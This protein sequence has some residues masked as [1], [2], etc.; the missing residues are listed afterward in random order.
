MI[1]DKMDMLDWL[2]IGAVLLIIISVAWRSAHVPRCVFCGAK[3]EYELTAPGHEVKMCAE[4]AR[5]FMQD[6]II[7]L[8]NIQENQDVDK[9]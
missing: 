7:I 3:A 2:M 8:R 1:I 9:E 4:H 5:R 6:G